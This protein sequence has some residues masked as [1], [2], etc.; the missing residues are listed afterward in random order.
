M[1]V[2]IYLTREQRTQITNLL[3]WLMVDLDL[4]L[5]ETVFSEYIFGINASMHIGLDKSILN[6]L[7]T[8]TKTDIVN[9]IFLSVG[10]IS[11]DSLPL[12]ISDYLTEWGICEWKESAMI[13]AVVKVSQSLFIDRLRIVPQMK[14]HEYSWDIY[15]GE[16]IFHVTTMRSS[17]SPAIKIC[18]RIG[19]ELLKRTMDYDVHPLHEDVEELLSAILSIDKVPLKIESCEY[20]TS[21]IKGMN[22]LSIKI[23][24]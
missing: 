3:K 9:L 10:T 1:A 24:N 14:R 17:F 18:L 23:S 12:R 13:S 11:D 6:A 5:N 4:E 8:A 15:V 21:N 19:D 22:Y 16:K 20:Q 7:P 2:T